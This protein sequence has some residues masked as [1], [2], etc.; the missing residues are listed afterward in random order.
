MQGLKEKVVA[1]ITRRMSSETGRLTQRMIQDD[2]LCEIFDV[3][4]EE[5]ALLYAS[6]RMDTDFWTP[7]SGRRRHETWL[8]LA[9]SERRF[10]NA[11]D[12]CKRQDAEGKARRY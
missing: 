7:T 1:L 4:H 6:N 3:C 12:F 8:N 10:F 5:R 9:Q 11:Q 2:V